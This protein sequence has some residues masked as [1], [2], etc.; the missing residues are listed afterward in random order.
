MSSFDDLLAAQVGNEF[1]ASQQ[2]IAVAAWYER[3]TLPELAG[4]FYRQA[5]EERNHA[6]ML[7]QFQL[8]TDRAIEL[9]GVQKPRSE[10][11]DA[12]E[13]V[14]VALAQEKRVTDQIKAMTSAA[15]AEDD[16]QA[17][18]FLQWFL[19]EQVEEVSSMGDLLATLEHSAGNLLLVE[20]YVV[21]ISAGG[22]GVD[23]TAPPAAGGAI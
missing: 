21:R 11:P 7:L 10:F 8:D 2:Y 3:A 19:K 4:F 22:G 20:D 16:F 9:P 15:R 18:Q 23:P 12:V 13:P 5:V 6:M 14:R 17:E 1:S